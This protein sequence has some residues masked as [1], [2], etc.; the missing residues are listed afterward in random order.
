VPVSFV[1]FEK[2][3]IDDVKEDI[4]DLSGW[5]NLLLAFGTSE[6]QILAPK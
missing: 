2:S 3:D 1:V 6:L 4:G 5:S